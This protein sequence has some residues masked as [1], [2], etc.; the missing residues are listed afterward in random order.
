MGGLKKTKHKRPTL[1]SWYRQGDNILK[2]VPL[3]PDSLITPLLRDRPG[4]LV[5]VLLLIV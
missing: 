2:L 1:G 5:S 3:K 4:F